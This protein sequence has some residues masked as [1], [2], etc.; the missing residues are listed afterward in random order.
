MANMADIKVAR[1]LGITTVEGLRVFLDNKKAL[2][3]VAEQETRER[4]DADKYASYSDYA[5]NHR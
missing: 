1:A 4:E 5:R 2:L 3:A